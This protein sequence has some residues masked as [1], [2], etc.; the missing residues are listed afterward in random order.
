MLLF[1]HMENIRHMLVVPKFSVSFSLFSDLLSL[2][3][4]PLFPNLMHQYYFLQV[5]YLKRTGASSEVRLPNLPSALLLQAK[6]GKL[7]SISFSGI[8]A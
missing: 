8:T 7:I 3:V 4:L 2:L 5:I 1:F 6:T